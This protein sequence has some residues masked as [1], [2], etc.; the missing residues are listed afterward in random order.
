[1]AAMHEDAW[2]EEGLECVEREFSAITSR[3][4]NV[5]LQTEYVDTIAGAFHQSSRKTLHYVPPTRQNG[6]IIIRPTKEV[7]DSG[8]NKWRSTAVG[9]FLGKRP[10]FPQVDSFVRSN[11]KGIQHVSV[12]SS[13]FF[14]FRFFR[15]LD[16]EDVIE[17]GP[18]L[19]QGQPIVLQP[20][21]QGMSLRRQKHT[22]IPVWIRLRHLP[23]EYW[24]DE[25]LSTVASGVGTPLYTDGI[26]KD[27]SRLDFARVCVML[28]FNSTLPKHLVVISPV[29]RNGKEDPKRIDVE[30]EWLPQRQKL[31]FFGTCISYLS[32]E[33]EKECS[34]AVNDIC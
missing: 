27:C 14:F 34:P 21:E 7:V 20:W 4:G 28:D 22:Q 29:L 1:M 33:R 25:G 6:E 17:G 26:T 9:Y 23:M 3:S 30:Y 11:W 15:R 32:G 12:S 2:E 31:L 13:G 16:M 10:Y 18:W 19:F 8:S 5:K 24:T